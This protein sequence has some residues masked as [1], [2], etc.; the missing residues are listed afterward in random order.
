MTSWNLP[1]L[2]L[3]SA[4]ATCHFSQTEKVKQNT[5]LALKLNIIIVAVGKHYIS[6][7]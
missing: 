6:P 5:L 4:S 1:V 3:V 7:V 2:T